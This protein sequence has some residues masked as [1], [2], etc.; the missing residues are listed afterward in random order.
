MLTK[1]TCSTCKIDKSFDSFSKNKSRAN[2]LH[3]QCKDCNKTQYLK[4][5][6]SRKNTMRKY[7]KD[8]TAAR[9]LKAKE[10]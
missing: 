3:S 4:N 8:N 10:Y 1:H 2:G 5:A 7:D 6:E 9:N